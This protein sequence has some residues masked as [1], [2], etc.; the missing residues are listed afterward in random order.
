MALQNWS[1]RLFQ[2]VQRDAAITVLVEDR[3]GGIAHVP[4]EVDLRPDRS[5]G[6]YRT[7]PRW[8]VETMTKS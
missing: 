6:L 5:S 8:C 1:Q 7:P 2:L 4:L 3:E